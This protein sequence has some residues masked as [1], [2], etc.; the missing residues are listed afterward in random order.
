MSS[1]PKTYLIRNREQRKRRCFHLPA[2]DSCFYAVIASNIAGLCEPGYA[3]WTGID[4]CYPC[5]LH[6]YQF[7]RGQKFCHKCPDGT[8][9]A[10]KAST[11]YNQCFGKC[12]VLLV[13]FWLILTVEP[14]LHAH[15][16][17][18]LP[19]PILIGDFMDFF[20]LHTTCLYDLASV[21][22]AYFCDYF[23]KVSA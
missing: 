5:P 18:Y 3:S 12:F 22:I 6:T 14:R 20:M 7:Q 15:N 9:T 13:G 4:P 16:W 1:I 8:N 11:S 2:A 19:R 10:S 23:F 21:I 17:F